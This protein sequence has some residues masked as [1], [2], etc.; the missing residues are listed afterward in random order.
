MKYL[1]A[2][3]Y[4]RTVPG[5]GT[6]VAEDI[7]TLADIRAALQQELAAPVASYPSGGRKAAHPH[8]QQPLAAAATPV[9]GSKIETMLE[10]ASVMRDMCALVMRSAVKSHCKMER[11]IPKRK[12]LTHL[13]Q[14][15][16]RKHNYEISL[17]TA[18]VVVL[19]L[20]RQTG[21]Q[22]AASVGTR[23]LDASAATRSGR[24]CF[25]RPA[26][27]ST[28]SAPRLSTRSG[29]LPGRCTSC[30][31]ATVT[32]ARK[33]SGF[34]PQSSWTGRRST[35]ATSSS[36]TQSARVSL[37]PL[38]RGVPPGRALLSAQWGWMSTWG[39]STASGRSQVVS[40]THP[41]RSLSLRSVSTDASR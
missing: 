25:R 30:A 28:V 23:S 24:Y 37:S 34:G 26:Q 7:G 39:A 22:G 20:N 15:W 4:V 35:S 2:R 8:N 17:A 13:V 32:K 41:R 3:G 6:F 12:E 5:T 19:P 16:G 38:S 36:K 21:L 40:R 33:A 14:Q 31:R 1:K 10:E 11:S 27:W 18:E 9:K 29:R